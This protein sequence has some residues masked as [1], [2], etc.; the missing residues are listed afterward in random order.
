MQSPRQ[1][2]EARVLD[3]ESVTLTT[4][5]P[6]L[7][8]FQKSAIENELKRSTFFK[9]ILLQL[10]ITS[11]QM[12]WTSDCTK[13]LTS[14]KERGD[15]KALKSLKKKQA[16]LLSFLVIL[17]HVLNFVCRL[18]IF[19][20]S[21]S[22]PVAFLHRVRGQ[23]PQQP[24]F[25]LASLSSFSP[26]LL[27]PVLLFAVMLCS[28]LNIFITVVINFFLFLLFF[29]FFVVLKLITLLSRNMIRIFRANR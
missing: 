27:A 16:S 18:P 4:R 2:L 26:I 15:K 8:Q 20:F 28:Q 29:L 9:N 11:S 14:T 6:H 22:G 13:A 17:S 21:L 12:Q 7:P 25:F 3:P 1:G 5:L 24:I 19:D 23:E 10:T